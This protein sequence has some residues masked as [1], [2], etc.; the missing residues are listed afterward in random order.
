MTKK[1]P[2]QRT[3]NPPVERASTVLLEHASDLYRNDIKTYGRLGLAA[4]D[5]LR[6]E[7]LKR[8]GGVA[9][10]LVSTGLQACTLSLLAV[11]RSGGHALIP[12]TAY[13]PTRRFAENMLPR[14]GVETE[15][16]APG[17]GAG[18]SELIRENTSVVYMESPGSLTLEIQDVRAIAEAAR[19]RGAVS[20]IDD[21]WGAMTCFRPLE[22]G[23][24]LAV[25]AATKY[26]SGG[27]DVFLGSITAREAKLGAAIA[28]Y[29]KTFGA[30]VSADD[31]YTVLRSMRSLD[32]R[33]ARHEASAHAVAQWLSERD[34]VVRV[35]FPGRP[36][37]P[38]HTLWQRDFK[39]SSGLL[40]AVFKTQPE[41]KI[42][43]FL[44]ALEVFGIGFSFGGFESLALWSD[45]QLKRNH[46]DWS[47]EGN[48]M[49][50]SIG[51]E[52]V[53]ELTE[54]LERGFKAMA[55]A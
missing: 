20:V 7:I 30:S 8:T 12:D 4:H 6:E 40:A 11:S 5:A 19:A 48:L 42:H 38:D 14:L 23:V 46:A 51:L 44:D 49:R 39:S 36:D 13:G 45:P 26:P 32:A 1:T 47:A 27:S 34:E 28:A 10:A 55:G 43:A 2:F 17:I 54:D 31:A 29:V 24:D 52:P 21:T 9:C 25:H 50:F 16:Y 33:L 35:I 41:A 53:A 18:I 3:A 15:F 37:H 22:L